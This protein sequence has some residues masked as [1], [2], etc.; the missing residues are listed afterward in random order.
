MAIQAHKD[1]SMLLRI[2]GITCVNGNTEVDNVTINVTR[3]LEIAQLNEVIS[4]FCALYF[5]LIREK[6]SQSH[7]KNTLFRFQFIVAQSHP[8]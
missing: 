6:K 2:I 1:P 5:S 8:L 4:V 7:V 3:I